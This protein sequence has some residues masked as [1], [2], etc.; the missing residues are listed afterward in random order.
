MLERIEGTGKLEKWDQP[1]GQHDVNYN[2]TI[3]TNIVERPG[4]PRVASTRHGQGTVRS[5]AGTAFPEGAYR[6][7]CETKS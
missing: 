4:F 6:L 1:D 7:F 3:T 2:F 5:T